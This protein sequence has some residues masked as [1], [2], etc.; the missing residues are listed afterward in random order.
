MSAVNTPGNLRNSPALRFAN[1]PMAVPG[2]THE[3]LTSDVD[4][5]TAKCLKDV[6]Q[7]MDVDCNG[8]VNQAE[9]RA[10][11]KKNPRGWPLADVLAGQPEGVKEQIVSFWFRKL[12]LDSSGSFDQDELVAFFRAM[13]QTK[14]KEMLYADFLLNLFDTNYDGKLDREE[15]GTMLRVLLGRDVP[16]YVLSSVSADGLTR[17]DLVSILHSIHCDFSQLDNRNVVK[18]GGTELI[19]VGVLLGAAAVLFVG[20]LSFLKRK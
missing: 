9:F 16:K 17:E 11:L 15:Y 19:L 5:E 18:A 10:Y 6:F 12:D 13:K 20:G 7:E 3:A 4:A 1:P 8:R 14:Y 2:I